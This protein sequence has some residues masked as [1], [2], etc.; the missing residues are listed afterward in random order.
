MESDSPESAGKGAR[1]GSGGGGAFA[2]PPR[3]R[4][5]RDGV[6]DGVGSGMPAARGAA[7]STSID[8]ADVIDTRVSGAWWREWEREWLD[9]VALPLRERALEAGWRPD[10]SEEYC[11]RCGWSVAGDGATEAGCSRCRGEKLP[12]ERLVR[13]GAYRPPLRGWVREVKHARARGLGEEL[14][15]VL[16]AAVG[17]VHARVVPGLR[18]CLVPVP[19]S[20][21]RRVVRGIDHAGC[22]AKGMGE[23]T[24][25]PVLR[26]LRRKWGMRQVGGTRVERAENARR[27]IESR[28]PLS[29]DGTCLVVLVDDICTTGATLAACSRAIINAAKA[30]G[31]D[32]LP[33]VWAGV[34]ARTELV[35]AAGA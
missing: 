12:W 3:R 16:G 8:E 14:G 29:L 32:G 28:G 6:Q 23:V 24:G 35:G 33:R 19:D 15:R 22:V 17:A 30:G 25:W 11:G 27:Q 18:P 21:M 7:R 31:C 13:L 4:L 9:P 1:E 2:W 10:E 20:I 34:L 26:P 5:P